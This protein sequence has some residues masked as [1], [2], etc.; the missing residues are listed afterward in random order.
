MKRRFLFTLGILMLCVAALEGQSRKT[1]C[2]AADKEKNESSMTRLFGMTT[3]EFE[4][5]GLCN[6]SNSEYA[7]LIAW[8]LKRGPSREGV[9][10]HPAKRIYVEMVF[11]EG[12]PN[13][14]KTAYLRALKPYKDVE[15][16]DRPQADL[17]IAVQAYQMKTAAGRVAAVLVA[18]RTFR[19]WKVA[20]FDG[21]KMLTEELAPETIGHASPEELA[22]LVA[23]QVAMIDSKVFESL[24]TQYPYVEAAK[25]RP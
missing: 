17:Q 2:D 25:H 15:V 4:K 6:L 7:S 1:I 14:V 13:E 12:T 24:R 5:S 23:D 10:P 11:G 9:D 16:V 20:D 19:A 18:A 8:T 22:A 3:E 21:Y